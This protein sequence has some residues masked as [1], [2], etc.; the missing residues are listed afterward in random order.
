MPVENQRD[1]CKRR[2]PFR[3]GKRSRKP[4]CPSNNEWKNKT[5]YT[6]TMEYYSSLKRKEN[7]VICC[8]VGEPGGH[9]A[10]WRRPDTKR[11]MPSPLTEVL[12]AAKPIEKESRAWLPGAGGGGELAFNEN[13]TQLCKMLTSG[14]G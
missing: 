10:E 3:I 4:K 11:Q 12:R 6:H 8:N 1:S 2:G 9:D 5:R 7:S 13:M 14:Q